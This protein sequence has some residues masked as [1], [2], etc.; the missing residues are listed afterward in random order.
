MNKRIPIF[1]GFILVGLAIW[2]LLDPHSRHWVSRLDNMVYDIQLRTRLLTE[3]TKPNNNWVVIVDINDKSLKA[4]GHWPWPRDI[5]AALITKLQ[6]QGAAVIAFDILFPEKEN[7][8]VDTVIQGLRAQKLLTAPLE[9]LL[10][11]NKNYFDKDAIFA[12]QLELNTV[13]LGMSFSFINITTGLLPSPLFT[14][15]S[16]ELDQLDLISAKGYLS[17][18]PV[19]QQAAKNAGFLNIMP[20]EDGIIRRAPLIINYKNGIYPSLALEAAR[21]Y[22][23]EN[24]K[25]ITPLYGQ[26]KQVEGIQFGPKVIP[27]DAKAQVLIPFIGRSYTFTYYSASDVLHDKI[28]ADTLAGKIVFVGSSATGL[29]DLKATAIQ[30]PYPGVEIQ[31]T[32]ANGILENNFSAKPAWA[33]GANIAL[34]VFFGSLSALV[35]PFLGPRILTVF[36]ILLPPLLIL[37]SNW[38]WAQTGLILSLLIPALLVLAE[39]ILNTLYGY[40][41]ESR[42]REHLKGMF[43]QY[44]PAKHIDEMLKKGSGD[45]LGGEDREMTVLFADIRSFT[46]LSEKMTATELKSMLNEFFTPMTE[47]IFKYKGTID[48]YVGDMIMAFW[49][50]PLYDKKH[51]QNAITAALEMQK[52]VTELAPVFAKKNYPEIHIGIGLN[53]GEMSVGDMGSKFRRNYT[54]LGDAVNLGSRVEGL[55]K[56]YGANIIVTESTQTNQTRFVFQQL[57]RVRVKGKKTGINIYEPLC[58]TSE[59]TEALKQELELHVVALRYY[60]EQQWS[61]AKSSFQHLKN[62]YPERKLYSLYL[63]RIEYYDQTPPDADW[64]GIYTHINK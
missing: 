27:T 55:T 25:L 23:G 30:T 19:L 38:I 64:D 60:F 8:A 2:L 63:E 3:K 16:E 59:L 14:L 5:L 10:E 21:T 51:A 26:I 57:D 49:G 15:S 33:L 7:N 58:L 48:K 29:G 39:A 56:F 45:S 62:L 6:A 50:A 13:V 28:P 47:I 54:V 20:D 11:K 35:F 46:T 24:I 4:E 34:I 44:V 43:G 53:T 40:L 42:R 37:I 41:F 12:K 17:D 32:L 31:A 52:K 22:L 36:V 1:L 9:T 61:L 18:V